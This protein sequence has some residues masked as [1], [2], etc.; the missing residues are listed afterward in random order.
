MTLSD[1]QGR[2]KSV[3]THFVERERCSTITLTGHVR[4]RRSPPVLRRR[5]DRPRLLRD[6][7]HEVVVLDPGV[8][9]DQLAADRGPGG[10]RPG[11]GRGRR[12]RAPPLPRTSRTT[13]WC[14]GSRR[15][16]GPRNRASAGTKVREGRPRTPSHPRTSSRSLADLQ[17][18]RT[19]LVDLMEYQAKEL[20]A[21]HGRHRHPRH[22][23]H[24]RRGGQGRRRGARRRAWSRRRSRPAAA[25]R[26]AASSSPRPPTRPSSTRRRSSGWRSRASRSTGCWSPRRRRR[27]RSTTSPSCSTAPT[28]STSASPASRAASRSRR[29]P[30]PTRT[31]SS[32]SRST[33]APASTRRRPARSSPRPSSRP[34]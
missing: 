6:A 30:R 19:S 32:R 28:G 12:P 24:H 16:R 5:P 22:R 10:R 29:S 9:A 34:S 7:G 25:A 13:S 31:P 4:V 1:A 23:R 18:A 3:S 15:R 33:R 8:S 11:R 17:R 20:F 27:W 21:K 14:S 26:P 2:P